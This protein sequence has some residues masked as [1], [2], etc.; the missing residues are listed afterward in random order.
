[1]FNAYGDVGY[2]PYLVKEEIAF[3]KWF[4]GVLFLVRLHDFI[5]LNLDPT[6]FVIVLGILAMVGC[7]LQVLKSKKN[8]FTHIL[9]LVSPLW[10]LLGTGYNEYYPFVAPFALI[11]VWYLLGEFTV[12]RNWMVAVFCGLLP[13]IY[14]GL[15]PFSFLLVLRSVGLGIRRCFSFIFVSIATFFITIFFFWPTNIGGFFARLKYESNLG[16]ANTLHI[17]YQKH[18][19]EGT[20]FFDLRF[21]FSIEHILEKIGMLI[22]GGGV[23]AFC[24]L[25][26]IIVEFVRRVFLLHRNKIVWSEFCIQLLALSQV[27]VLILLIPKL[28]PINDRDFLS[29]FI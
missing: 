4:L 28:G 18:S 27:L 17:P 14:L 29:L 25:C 15:T 26:V 19:L 23:F 7:N 9:P 12:N 1:M 3:T 13:L 21:A 6:D 10:I 8:G 20:P 11:T 22:F 16:E 2:L 5:P 24:G